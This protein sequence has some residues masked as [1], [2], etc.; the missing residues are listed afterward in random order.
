MK[1]SIMII[2][3]DDRWYNLYA[4]MLE[5]SDYE[6]IHAH[7]GLQALAFLEKNK[8]DLIILDM[9][10]KIVTGETFFLFTK[11]MPEYA[12]IPFIIVSKGRTSTYNNLRHFD[13]DVIFLNRFVTRENLI[14]EIKEKIG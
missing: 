8:P 9:F 12:D 1:K 6:T 10:L 13:P 4:A 7:S 5:N 3:E 11:S 14:E 2:N